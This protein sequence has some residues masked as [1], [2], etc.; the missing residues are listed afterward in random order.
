MLVDLD[1]EQSLRCFMKHVTKSGPIN[2]S[3]CSDVFIYRVGKK[4]AI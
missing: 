4:N 2:E 3:I 1:M